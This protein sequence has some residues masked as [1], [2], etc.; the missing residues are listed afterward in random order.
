MRQIRV[1]AWLCLIGSV[2]AACGGEKFSGPDQSGTMFQGPASTE[3]GSAARGSTAGAPGGNET[4]DA[5]TPASGGSS[6]KATSGG[7]GGASGGSVSASGGSQNASGSSFVA[8]SGGQRSPG[9]TTNSCG[10]S[11]VKFKM[12]PGQNLPHDYLCDASCGTG[13]LSIT[14]AAGATAFSLFAS[15]GTASCETCEVQPCTASACYPMPLGQ[16]GSELAWDG[17]YVTRDTCGQNMAC[18]KP[19]CA[20]PG[21]YKAKACA[22]INAGSDG[23]GQGCAPKTEMLCA[24]AEF[25]FPGDGDVKLVLQK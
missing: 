6:G 11:S 9:A 2:T 19:V 16:D 5:A 22:S 25:D 21:R 8:G 17:T 15:C 3:G 12:L 23:S 20:K 7:S 10:G 13:W 18:Q 1:C 14:D 4:N 24:E